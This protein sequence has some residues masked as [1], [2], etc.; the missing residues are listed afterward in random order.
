MSRFSVFA[1]SFP[2]LLIAGSGDR[3]LIPHNAIS[4]INKETGAAILAVACEDDRG[5]VKGDTCSHEGD[6]SNLKSWSIRSVILGHFRSAAG[7]EA[8]VI[9]D[10]GKLVFAAKSNAQWLV[11]SLAGTGFYDLPGVREG[12]CLRRKARSGREFLLCES[13]V[14]LTGGQAGYALSSVMFEPVTSPQGGQRPSLSYSL[15]TRELLLAA[16][17]TGSCWGGKAQKAEVQ[18]VEVRDLNADGLEDISITATIGFFE[19]TGPLIKQCEAARRGDA[20]ALYPQPSA[21]K[22]LRI[23]YLFNGLSYVL[24]PASRAA[25][26]LLSTE[27]VKDLALS[28][29]PARLQR[30][31]VAAAASQQ[32]LADSTFRDLC[33]AP[34]VDGEC[35]RFL[36][37]D[38]RKPWSLRAAHYG[39]FLSPTSDDVVISTVESGESPVTSVWTRKDGKWVDNPW[40]G[41][42]GWQQD[43]SDC[44]KV[45]F[46]TGVDR[47]VCFSPFG[48][49]YRGYS[50][51]EVSGMRGTQ[52]QVWFE[53]LMITF[54]KLVECNTYEGYPQW[55]TIV[56]SV[57]DSLEVRDSGKA[58]PG[59]L[60]IGFRYGVVDVAPR[61]TEHQCQ[62]SLAGKP[63]AAKF[64]VPVLKSYRIEWTAGAD[65]VFQLVNVPPG[66]ELRP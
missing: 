55:N 31:A 16:D 10:D 27:A 59:Y 46:P 1:I 18:K 60:A 20:S 57:L 24:A 32:R 61:K 66:V 49:S 9:G 52:G 33:A 25:A 58:G 44:V 17:T 41:Y 19:M 54:E 50:G 21:V 56:K 53:S 64:P 36:R 7:E 5:V 8:I 47:M 34:I 43:I 15:R 22:S 26:V 3:W 2:C 42:S 48:G 13:S 37:E 29:A 14:D 51:T 40:N 62:D 30:P 63:G 28:T 11:L 35:T 38:R 12:T 65:G 4:T 39:H 45:T 6:Y 23:D